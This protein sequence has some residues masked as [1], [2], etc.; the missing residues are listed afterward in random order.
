M[1]ARTFH[2]RQVYLQYLQSQEGRP[3]VWGIGIGPGEAYQPPGWFDKVI[4]P[5]LGLGIVVIVRQQHIRHAFSTRVPVRASEGTHIVM[6]TVYA[7]PVK[8]D[9]TSV[10]TWRGFE[11]P[12]FLL[13]DKFPSFSC[14]AYKEF[15]TRS[16]VWDQ[17][18][19]GRTSMGPHLLAPRWF[20]QRN[21]EP[22]R[23]RLMC[24]PPASFE[25]LNVF[26]VFVD[27]KNPQ[28]RSSFLFC[29]RRWAST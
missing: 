18:L 7:M 15:T 27:I 1:A 10:C 26:G 28:P 4:F 20:L 3:V 29:S 14:F 25:L 22:E 23:I 21:T 9:Y 5:P 17:S 8:S 19:Q 12:T 16:E 6:I 2:W 13:T 11:F 24:K